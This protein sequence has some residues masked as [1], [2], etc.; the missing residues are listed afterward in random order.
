VS[1]AGLRYA[2]SLLLPGGPGAVELRATRAEGP[3]GWSLSARLELAAP[4]DAGPAIAGVRRLLDLDVDPVVVD[5]ALAA[6]PVLAPLVAATPGIRAPGAVD[7]HEL[8]VRAFVG[9]QISV[10]A[11][12]TSS[13]A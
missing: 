10:A 7:P 13:A 2:R 11:A 3:S 5:D 4:D 8:V 12:R 6:D 1:G 9:Q